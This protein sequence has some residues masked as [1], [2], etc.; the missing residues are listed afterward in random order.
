MA[1][2]RS[3]FPLTQKNVYTK[4]IKFVCFQNLIVFSFSL[5]FLS[6]TFWSHY[7]L[8]GFLYS[9]SFTNKSHPLWNIVTTGTDHRIVKGMAIVNWQQRHLEILIL[10]NRGIWSILVVLVDATTRV[11]GMLFYYLKCKELNWPSSS[12]PKPL[13]IL[14]CPDFSNQIKS[15][16]FNYNNALTVIQLTNGSRT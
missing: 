1:W 9:I 11:I 7:R 13:E 6:V 2:L 3:M 15:T 4:Y 12:Q 10:S 5:Q 14:H 16:L 8:A